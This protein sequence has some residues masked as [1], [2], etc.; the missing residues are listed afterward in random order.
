MPAVNDPSIIKGESM[1][2]RI[3]SREKE[4]LSTLATREGMTVSE[5]LRSLVRE[6]AKKAKL[7]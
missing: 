4:I 2:L 3:S 7:M 5:Y 6:Q 1:R